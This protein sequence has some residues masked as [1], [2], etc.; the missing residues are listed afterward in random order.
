MTTPGVF[1][2]SH[3]ALNIS[4]NPQKPFSISHV[5][6]SAGPVGNANCY[7]SPS[8]N[9]FMGQIFNCLIGQNLTVS[10]ICY[11]IVM[12]GLYW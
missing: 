2:T 1:F 12:E 9:W 4:I 7:D 3:F 8:E 5:C 10:I 6:G 11:R